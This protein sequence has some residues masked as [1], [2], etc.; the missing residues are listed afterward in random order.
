MRKLLQIIKQAFI[1]IFRN[2]G[3]SFLTIL[4]IIIGIASVIALISL[5]K[6][7]QSNITGQISQLGTT[8]LTISPGQSFASAGS[9][10]IGGGGSSSGGGSAVRESASTLTIQDYNSLSDTT[11]HP[12]I[13]YISGE[14]GGS[15]IL[16]INGTDTR[17]SVLGTSEQFIQ[18]RNYNLADGAYFT[19]NNLT[20]TSD[21]AV[22]GNTFAINY[23]G[24][25]YPINKT[26]QINSLTFTVIG[27]LAEQKESTFNNPNNQIYIPYTT[28]MKVFSSQ[29]F[30]DMSVQ[31]TN[32]QSVNDLKTDINNTLL[33][34][35]KITDS[36]LADF[37][38]LTSADLLSTV[39]TITNMLTSLLAGIAGISLLVGG[40]GIMNIMLVSVTER[41]REIGLRKAVGAKTSDILIQFIVEAVLLT[42]IGGIIG[43]GL[44]ILGGRIGAKLI[45]FTADTNTSSILLA[46]GVSSAVGLV[47]G[48]YPAARAARLNPIDALRYE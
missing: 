42:L 47:F 43:I 41:T 44:G 33:A 37:S 3:R 39:T 9:G 28:A 17:I 38:V 11:A 27:V 31:A 13:K 12:L 7:V 23:F 36:K 14:V 46:V 8:N 45:G 6:G 34:N 19:K 40:I 15:T 30:S 16:T 48:I 25:T 22:L 29:T 26:I 32:D 1:A 5:G 18:L 20:Q 35:H 4:G 10:K 21:V 24:S 2:K